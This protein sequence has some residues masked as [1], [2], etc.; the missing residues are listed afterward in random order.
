VIHHTTPFLL[1]TGTGKTAL[2]VHLAMQ[3]NFE[4]IKVF[5]ASAFLRLPA[6]KKIERFTDA[7]KDATKAKVRNERRSLFLPYL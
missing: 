5:E 2:A 4:Y 1:L 3:S 7:F 6:D